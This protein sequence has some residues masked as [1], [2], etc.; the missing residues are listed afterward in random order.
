M[1][2]PDAEA[3]VVNDDGQVVG[4]SYVNSTPNSVTGFPTLHPFL[5][6]KG[7]MKDLGTLC[8]F[9]SP[10]SAT[11][12]PTVGV[13]GLNNRGQVI[14]VSPLAGDLIAHPFLWDDGNLI[15]LNVQSAGLISTADAINDARQ[16]VGNANFPNGASDA[17]L[18]QDGVFRDLGTLSG[19]CFSEA[20]AINSRGQVVGQSYSCVSNTVRTFLWESGSIVDLNNLIPPDSGFELIEALAIN[21]RGEIGGIADPPG[22]ANLDDADCGHAFLLIP[23]DENHASVEGCNYSEVEESVSA[24]RAGSRAVAQNPTTTNPWIPG[25]VNPMM[26]SFGRRSMP[27]YRNLGVQP[28]SK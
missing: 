5:W 4:V 8:G 11:L 1:G 23:C 12:P 3:G 22:C 2:G 9:G 18:W 21:D 16:I 26:R 20:F 15:D 27:W 14:G 24:V 17:Y 28:P 6:H 25:R 13:S 19:D 7:R 10:G